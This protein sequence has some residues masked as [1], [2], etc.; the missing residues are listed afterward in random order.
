MLS[1][2][3]F[4]LLLIHSSDYLLR[5]DYLMFR[6]FFCLAS[7]VRKLSI[8]LVD[9]QNSVFSPLSL[10]N[11]K[12]MCA[13]GVHTDPHSEV[14]CR[15]PRRSLK[16]MF[17]DLQFV[18]NDKPTSS[19]MAYVRSTRDETSAWQQSPHRSANAQAPVTSGC[20]HSPT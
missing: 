9:R 7:V 6:N 15:R 14:K 1:F 8:V 18:D 16:I 2:S 5:E 4:V 3:S 11:S 20:F 17:V 19:Y 13:G 12:F 10:R